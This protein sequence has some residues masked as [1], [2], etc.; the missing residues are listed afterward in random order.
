MCERIEH[1]GTKNTTKI[2]H[3][4]LQHIF[5]RPQEVIMRKTGNHEII[6][7][8]REGSPKRKFSSHGESGKHHL[9]KTES[10]PEHRRMFMSSTHATRLPRVA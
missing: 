3:A 8:E 5:H 4:R 9:P 2:I 7:W 10:E 1:L 6:H